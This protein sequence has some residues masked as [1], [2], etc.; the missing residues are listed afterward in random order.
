[1]HDLVVRNACI[2]DGTGAKKF[3]G[4]VAVEGAHIVAV[5]DDVGRGRRELDAEG[6]LLTPGWVDVHTHYDGQVSWD[7]Q[8]TPSS[9]HGVTTVV[10]GNCGVGFAPVKP[11]EHEALIEIME[12]VEDIPGSALAEGIDWQWESFP[13]YLD[14]IAAKPRVLDVGAQMPH[15]AIRAYVMGQD[16]AYRDVATDDEIEKMAAITRE[17]LSAGALGFTTSRTILHR[18]KH[19]ELIPGTSASAQELLAM[20]RAIGEAGH[21]VFEMVSDRHGQK[22]EL[23]WMRTLCGHTS[24]ALTYAVA[25]SPTNPDGWRDILE[26]AADA[27]K[28]GL[29]FRPQIPG[30]PTGMLFGFRTSLHPF[31]AHPSFHRLTELG[32]DE[33]IAQLKRPEVRSRILA[34]KPATQNPMALY[35]LANF[36]NF[37]PLA[38]CP[39][40]EPTRE[41][42]LKAQAK[43]KG[44]TPQEL[45][46]DLML[47]RD[48]NNYLFAPLGNYA[49]YN[50]DHL[51]EMLLHPSTVL[52]LSDGGAHCGLI[53]DAGIATYMLT[54]WVRDRSRGERLP[55][56]FVVRLQTKDTASM[57]RLHDRGVIAPGMKADLNIIDLDGLELEEPIMTYDLPLGGRRITQRAKGY[58]ATVCAG[59]VT[60]QDGQPTGELPGQLIRG[61]QKPN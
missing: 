14:A 52:G 37:F 29:S 50:H 53:A 57:Y 40:Y 13:E 5:G 18:D 60:Q 15:C 39:D 42:S 36:A 33:M 30:R 19:R 4:E 24:G 61:P 47:E 2:V 34:D 58:R 49:N 23:A 56:E 59:V 31:R 55:L 45:A 48:A 51:R 35:L 3:H 54:H 17:G 10:M 11:D 28:A 25:Q 27:S 8:I 6:N 7:P 22:E 26:T 16:G 20:G 12:A 32:V 1:M 46:Y 41:Q 44:V 43:D 21:G 9:W 38:E